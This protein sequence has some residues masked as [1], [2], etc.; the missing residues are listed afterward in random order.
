MAGDLY[1]LQIFERENWSS[2]SP[3]KSMKSHRRSP[4][5]LCAPPSISGEM[6]FVILEHRAL[7]KLLM[8]IRLRSRSPRLQLHIP[9]SRLFFLI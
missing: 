7:M 3:G 2:D 8:W 1:S 6:E 4:G 5:A 9:F